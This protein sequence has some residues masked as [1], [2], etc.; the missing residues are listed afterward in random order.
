MKFSQNPVDAS[1]LYE[2]GFVKF[3]LRESDLQRTN[4][5]LNQSSNPAK[6]D[7]I[8]EEIQSSWMKRLEIK[9]EGN[10]KLEQPGWEIHHSRIK[11]NGRWWKTEA[12]NKKQQQQ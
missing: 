9:G 6:K 10:Q 11:M 7:R 3:D 4:Q 8:R 12:K 2:V 1:E 5:K